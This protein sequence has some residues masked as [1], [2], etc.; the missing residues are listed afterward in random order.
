MHACSSTPKHPP[1]LAAAVSCSSP[2]CAGSCALREH[3]E[4]HDLPFSLAFAHI[5]HSGTE[6]P[7]LLDDYYWLLCV[8]LMQVQTGFGR[9]GEAFWAFE[10]QRV[11][12]DIVTMGKPMGM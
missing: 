3:Q 8:T 9:V 7:L 10:L 12:P 2:G 6:Q 11:V 5:C 1:L 4:H